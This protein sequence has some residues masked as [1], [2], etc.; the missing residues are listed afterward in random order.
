[1]VDTWL[2]PCVHKPRPHYVFS[3]LRDLGYTG[4]DLRNGAVWAQAPRVIL[5]SFCWRIT[6]A[7]CR[8]CGTLFTGTVPLHPGIVSLFPPCSCSF[9]HLL[10][11][12]HNTP[13]AYAANFTPTQSFICRYTPHAAGGKY[14]QVPYRTRATFSFHYR[15]DICISGI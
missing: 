2:A 13:C 9:L 8:V 1:M 7:V 15:N 6:Q 14:F 11:L 10:S 12:C 3:G 5:G 4:M